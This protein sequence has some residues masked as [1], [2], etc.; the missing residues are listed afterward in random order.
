MEINV[1]APIQVYTLINSRQ[2]LFS[3]Q[4]STDNTCRRRHFI[5]IRFSAFLSISNGLFSLFS[6][7]LCCL[8]L[9]IH[10]WTGCGV[11][12]RMRSRREKEKSKREKARG[13]GRERSRKRGSGRERDKKRKR[14][15]K[16]PQQ[17]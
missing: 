2:C 5:A 11:F 15:R 14:Y 9:S 4:R 8:Y 12:D 17:S 1:R 7:S 3:M 13:V 6:L 10:L 16:V